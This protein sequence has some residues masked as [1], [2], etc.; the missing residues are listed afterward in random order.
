[1]KI[2]GRSRRINDLDVVFR[3]ELEKPLQACARMLSSH[4]FE[5]VGQKQNNRTQ[6][7]PFVLSAGDELINDHLS[8]VDEV[9]ELGLPENQAVRTIETVTVLKT[10]NSY[11]RE[12]AVINLYRRLFGS[13][14]LKGN[15][16]MS[17][18]IVVKY[19]MSLAEGSTDA[20]LAGET[21]TVTLASKAGEGQRLGG[22]P[23]ERPFALGHF[24]PC[25]NSPYDL[26]MRMKIFGKSG[27]R[28]EKL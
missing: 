15:V 18:L 1:M 7:V 27:L 5:S 16:Q 3:G 17:I 9:T 20:I 26:G 12:R 4:P 2:L 28:I 21:N 19:G 14:V 23:V 13:H 8:S 10:Q 24:A 25:P 22:R 6:P 11:L